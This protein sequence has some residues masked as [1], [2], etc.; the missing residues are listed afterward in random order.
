MVVHLAVAEGQKELLHSWIYGVHWK[1][2]WNLRSP[3]SNTLE[4]VRKCNVRHMLAFSLKIFIAVN[5][6]V[7]SSRKITYL[8]C[9]VL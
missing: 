7:N 4:L 9:I 5:Y 3:D 1:L 2:E 6:E 8:G